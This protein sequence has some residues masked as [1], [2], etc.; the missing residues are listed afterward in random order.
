MCAAVWRRSARKEATAHTMPA[1][2]DDTWQRA[3]DDPSVRPPGGCG[4]EVFFLRCKAA[5][6]IFNYRKHVLGDALE[7]TYVCCLVSAQ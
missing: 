2:S 3:C 7:G 5:F 6:L 1:V 4:D